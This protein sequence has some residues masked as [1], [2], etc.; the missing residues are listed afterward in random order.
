MGDATLGFGLWGI[1][2][3]LSKISN[4]LRDTNVSHVAD[5]AVLAIGVIM[6]TTAIVG[7]VISPAL[8]IQ[9]DVDLEKARESAAL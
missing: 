3:M 4:H 5:W 1:D 2:E 9:A 7:T 6:L 8:A